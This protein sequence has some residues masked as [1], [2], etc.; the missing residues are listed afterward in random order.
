MR[1][2]RSLPSWG[3]ASRL[4][5][6]GAGTQEGTQRQRDGGAWDGAAGGGEVWVRED[7][8]AVTRQLS[9]GDTHGG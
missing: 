3:Q 5:F 2:L 4:R 6:H 9:P 7:K 1:L 8:L